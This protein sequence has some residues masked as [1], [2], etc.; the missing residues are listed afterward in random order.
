MAG[1]ISITHTSAYTLIDS[2]A[3]HSLVSANFVKKLDMVHDLLDEMCIV[4]L[5]SRENLTSQFG[6]KDVPVEIAGREL[7]VDLMVLKMVDYDLILGMDWLS[8]YYASIFCRRKNVV[9]QPSK[10]EIFEYKGTPRGS[11]WPVVSTMKANRMLIKGCVGYLASVVDTT[12]KVVTKQSNMHVVCRFPDVFPEELPRLPPNQEIEFEI[13]LLLGTTPIS[14]V[15]Y[16]MA[17]AEL[18]ELKQQLQDLLDKKF[19]H[20]SYAP[21]GPQYFS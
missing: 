4:S 15:P 3:S 14:K 8:K 6:F 10:V 5:P 2:R 13:E 12:I 21:W 17:P 7:P 1:Q 16:R 18:K 11:K 9:F 19:I 20:P